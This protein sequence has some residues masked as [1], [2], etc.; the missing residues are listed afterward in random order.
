MDEKTAAYIQCTATGLGLGLY[1]LAFAY[2]CWSHHQKKKML[3]PIKH[4]DFP[5]PSSVKLEDKENGERRI[6]PS[7]IK[8]VC[9]DL[10][11]N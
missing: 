2:A 9:A 6:D 3:P 11:R 8:A 7:F 5:S 10:E 4:N 1:I